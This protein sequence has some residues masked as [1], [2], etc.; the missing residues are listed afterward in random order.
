MLS[1]VVMLLVGQRAVAQYYS[2]GADAPMRWQQLRGEGVR[3][4]APDTTEAIARRVLHYVEA[5]RPYIGAGFSRGAMAVPFVL[6][7][8][9]MESNALVMYLPKRV[10][11]LTAPAAE[12][13]SMPW[14]K[15]L[16]AHEYRHAVQYNNLNRGVPRVLSWLLGEQGSVTSLL[17]M[18]LWALEG[19]AV[20][21]ETAMSTFGRGLQPSFSMAYRA[22]GEG[23]GLSYK[24][25]KR[26]NIDRWFC[27]SYRDYIPDH[28][29]LGYQLSAYAYDRYGENVW[30]KVGRYAVRNPYLFATTH[31]G[32]K[33]FYNT[34]T[35]ELFYNTF[36]QLNRHWSPLAEV[37]EKSHRLVEP[38]ARDHTTYRWPQQLTET[39]VVAV[40]SSLA[41]T[42]RIVT[43]D[44]EGNE[45]EVAGVGNLSSRPALYDG[46]LYWSEYENSKLFEERV[47]SQLWMVD[48][49]S[50]SQRPRRLRE[51]KANALYP[52][53]ST[54]GLAWVEYLPE[55]RY[56]LCENGTPIYT[57]PIGVELHGLAW[58]EVTKAYY[59]IVTDDA[60]MSLARLDREGMHPLRR[61]AY[62]TLRD[63]RAA[64]GKLYFGSI[65]SGKDEVHCLD[66]LAGGVETRLSASKYGAFEPA[67]SPQGLLLTTYDKRGYV[68][69]RLTEPVQD[70]VLW[71][72]TPVNLVTPSR[73]IW[74]TIN[75]DTVHF[76]PEMESAQRAEQPAKRYRKFFRGLKLHSWAPIAF[77]PYEVIDEHEF[78]PNVGLTLLSQNLLSNT[79]AYA[80]YGWDESEGSLFRVGL[81]NNSLG[82]RLSLDAT[83]GG[84]Q[85]CYSVGYY[86]RDSE[87]YY[88]Q[89]TP[90]L[91]DYYS[92]TAAATLPLLYDRGRSVRQLS[93]G[94]GWNYSNGLVSDLDAV[95]WEDGKIT[96]IDALSYNEGLHKMSLS[97]AFAEQVKLAHRD[98]LP[99]LGYR[100]QG[101]YS[102]NPTNN[103]FASSFVLYG[104]A[105]LPGVAPHHSLQ[106]EAAYQAAVGGYRTPS[107]SRLLTYR[108]SLL[109]PRGFHSA[110]L[111]IDNGLTTLSANYRLP[112]CYPEGGIPSVLYIKRIRLGAGFDYG[113]FDYGPRSYDVWSVGGEVAFDF[114]VLRM[115]ESA[116]SSL[117]VQCFRTSQ[118]E[119]WLS[120]SLGLPF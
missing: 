23:V 77:D 101:G 18:P 6:H 25:K 98:F 21:N 13:Y 46:K 40:K 15:Q 3:V 28:Y 65:Q 95:Q 42:P 38:S 35:N 107:G 56:R 88:Y 83:Y 11:Y 119:T 49:N 8:E 116:T 94:V 104:S 90:R 12:S 100:L 30:D 68:P 53:P 74:P 39:E 111:P 60:G 10:D 120:L 81:R 19:D 33:R 20:M 117:T 67:P 48:F 22:I 118:D 14:W 80:S 110:E 61:P 102:F 50:V 79:E 113:A 51:V 26:K 36:E 32:L 17:F 45:R 70:T 72:Q 112:L 91:D 96:N 82:L 76:T 71:S 44:T 59:T 29:A 16:V 99:R 105:Y 85:Q 62:I 41:R 37:E 7:P 31:V 89:P 108:S 93:L 54:Q 103:D 63:L 1:V 78:R 97:V 4:I 58:D 106:F 69:A 87:T 9:N 84:Y 114:N 5:A 34:T 57:L 75:L 66:L 27:G 115:P 2:W 109:L 73:R 92:I 52:T 64:D 43:I 55:G 86:D 24:G 47:R